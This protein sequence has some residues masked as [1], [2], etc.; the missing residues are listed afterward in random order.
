ME[1]KHKLYR[2]KVPQKKKS[3]DKA[4]RHKSRVSQKGEKVAIERAGTD[5]IQV[6]GAAEGREGDNKESANTPIQ[7]KG[8]AEEGERRE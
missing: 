2:S 7:I 4:S 8:A 1:R 5:A 6:K 3:D